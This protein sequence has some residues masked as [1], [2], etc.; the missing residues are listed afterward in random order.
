YPTPDGSAIRDY[1]HVVDLAK[2]HVKAL[3]LLE[4]E[5]PAVRYDVFNIG[6]GQGYSVL[7]VI[8]AFEKSTDVKLNY[9]LAPRRE[10]DIVQVWGNVEKS[11]K[12][13]GW[14]AELSLQDMMLSAWKWERY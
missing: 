3:E 4:K 5:N 12:E 7:E 1:I 11:K 8:D 6:T 13:L 2:A 14:K 9:T 10:G